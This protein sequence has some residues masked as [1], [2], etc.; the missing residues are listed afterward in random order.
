MTT[1]H[2]RRG[3]ILTHGTPFTTRTLGQLGFGAHDYVWSR[4]LAAYE[5]PSHRCTTSMSAAMNCGC[6]CCSGQCACDP[7][8]VIASLVKSL[9]PAQRARVV[10]V[11][12]EPCDVYIGNSF[13][14]FTSEG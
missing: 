2:G 6:L 4:R 12:D 5:L 3:R 8:D 14:T 9:P 13:R 11:D 7:A 1:R 10:H